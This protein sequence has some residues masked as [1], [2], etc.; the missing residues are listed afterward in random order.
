MPIELIVVVK[1]R[2]QA[3]LSRE[4]ARYPSVENEGEERRAKTATHRHKTKSKKGSF[5]SSFASEEVRC[6]KLSLLFLLATR[7]E[8][9]W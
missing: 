8:G 6:V 5:F 3:Y 1:A 7:K 9:T 2:K 4:S